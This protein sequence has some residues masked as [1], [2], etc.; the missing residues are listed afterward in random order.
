MSS[1]RPVARAGFPDGY[2]AAGVLLHPTCL[3]SPYGIGDLG[4]AAHAWIDALV[5]A[6]QT[7]WQFLP[8]GQALLNDS[9]YSPLCSFGGNPLLISPDGLID[10]GLLVRDDVAGASFPD[11]YVDYAAV[12]RFKGRLWDV[13]YERFQAGARADLKQPFEEF[14]HSHQHW[15][16]DFALFVALKER[17]QG[18]PYWQWAPGLV[19]REEQAL[20]EARRELA[21]PIHR[22][23]FQQFLFHRQATRLVEHA[24]R[25]GLKLIDDLP[26]FVSADSV[27]VWSRPDLFLLDSDRRP[28]VVAGVPPDYFSPTGQLWGNPHYDWPA[29]QR[30]HYAWWTE[31]IASRLEYVDLVRIDHFRAFAAAW[32]VAANAETAV[33]GAWVPGPGADFFA[34]LQHSLG[35]LPLL[36]EDLGMITKDVLKLRDQFHL[37]GMRVLQFAFDGD[38]QNTFLPQNFV[39]NTVAYTG[40]HDNDTTRGWYASLLPEPRAAVARLLVRAEVPDEEVSWDLIRTAHASMAAL[41]IVPLQDLLN[42]GSE[43]RMNVPGVPDGNWRWRFTPTMPVSEALS[44]LRELTRESGR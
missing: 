39:H 27:D 38:P 20:N 22:V 28:T 21:D 44:R 26:I 34:H 31:R 43:A 15:L 23:R 41:V 25:A 1:H 17:H 37:P 3:P 42:L 24:R 9:P 18:A 29:H 30:T 12:Q 40:T 6:G 35:G 5:A 10:G 8:L 16:E 7:W 14:C 32:H 19:H 36:A 4:P 33:D 13:A 2:R 11:D